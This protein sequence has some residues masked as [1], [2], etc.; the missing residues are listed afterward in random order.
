MKNIVVLSI[1]F[2]ALFSCQSNIDSTTDVSQ[3]EHV[4]SQEI[5]VVP[6]KILA[7]EVSGMSCA[8]ACGGTIRKGLKATNGVSAV[9]FDFEMGRETNIA[10]IS[11]DKEVISVE[12]M[13]ALVSKLNKGQFT[14]GAVSTSDLSLNTS[15]SKESGEEEVQVEMTVSNFKIPNLL[16]L[17][18]GIL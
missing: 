14:V 10:N 2:T 13:S 17:F 12:E 9:Q 4:E 1:I 7:M 6:N 11:F 16:D 8:M 3:S 5:T 15:N 18:S